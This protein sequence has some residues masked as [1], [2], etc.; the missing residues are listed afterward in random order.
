MLREM[1]GEKASEQTIESVIG[2]LFKSGGDWAVM[3]T[4]LLKIFYRRFESPGGEFRAALDEGKK[5]NIPV[6]YGD[7]DAKETMNRLAAV[8][9]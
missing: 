8:F 3:M 7:R 5:M 2:S 1:A 4:E 9:T 6:I